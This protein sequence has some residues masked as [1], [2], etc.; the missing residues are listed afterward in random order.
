MVVMTGCA[1]IFVSIAACLAAAGPQVSVSVDRERIEVGQPF[2][3]IVEVQG[4]DIGAIS[5]PDTTDLVVEKQAR[6]SETRINIV[7]FRT[8]KVVIRG[9]EATATRAG[10]LEVPPIAVTVDKQTTKSDSLKLNVLKSTP[11]VPAPV[12]PT[13]S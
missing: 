12:E 9:F 6:L 8:T 3:L 10:T 13:V 1:H 5:I 11:I 7:N 2:M 4:G